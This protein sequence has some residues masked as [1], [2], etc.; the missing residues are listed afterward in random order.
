MKK[1]LVLAVDRD[2]DFGS[3]AGVITP[4][5]GIEGCVEAAVALGVKDPEDSDVN[6]LFAAINIFRE[7]KEDGKPVE[8]SLVCGDQ[9]V[10]HRSDNA[11]IDELE[12]VLDRVQPDRVI[13]VGDGAE[14]E[15]VYPIISSRVH[16]D[17]V[18]KVFVKQA[19]GIEGTL[20]IFSKMI[21]DPQ[22]RKRFLVPIG[23]LLVLI[24]LIF[25]FEGLFAYFVTDDG[26]YIYGQTWSIISLI[27]GIVLLLYGYN[28]M[29]K[30]IDS[31][32]DDIRNIKSGDITV[33]FTIL[34][35]L[36]AIIGI[37]MGFYS[38]WDIRINDKIY[39]LITFVSNAMWPII[40]AIVFR[41]GGKVLKNYMSY[42]KVNRSFMIGTNMVIALG[43]IMQGALDMLRTFL[44]YAEVSNG[45]I[46]AEII[47]G[48]VFAVITSIL[49]STF[50][51][52]FKS[53]EEE[54]VDEAE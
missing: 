18:K 51:R 11:V 10:G 48:I 50:S 30:I 47:I 16:I 13:L 19:P 34:S 42:K 21:N 3:K 28:V 53:L 54:T 31:L 5:I 38:I 24:G 2:N 23:G 44:G 52:Y 35:L 25:L 40:F 7:L 43:F 12:E 14:D 45:V 32:E 49:Q 37:C 33:T 15:N 4:V 29:D 20:Y 6:G 1:T 22:K 41:D 26:S 17:S 27:L 8:I 46:M 9:K 36:M 39:F